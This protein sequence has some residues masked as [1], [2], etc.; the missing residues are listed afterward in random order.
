MEGFE[1]SLAKACEEAVQ[2]YRAN[3]KETSD[4]LDLLNDATEEYKASLKR[5]NPSFDTEYYDNLILEQEELQTPAIEDSV[6]FDQLDPIR[7]PCNAAGRST[8]DKNAEASPSQATDQLVD[9]PTA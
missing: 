4:Y 9:Q 3:F 2:E 6:R 8:A 1:A 5:V 7:T